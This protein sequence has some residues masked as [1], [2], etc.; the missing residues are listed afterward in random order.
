MSIFKNDAKTFLF[1]FILG[2]ILAGGGWW[3][4]ESPL[5]DADKG[6]S[7]AQYAV[8]YK[9]SVAAIVVGVLLIGYWLY[10]TVTHFTDK[11]VDE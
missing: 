4:M 7:D 9:L 6:I 11:G 2:V 5:F 3:A 10:K 1:T 8:I